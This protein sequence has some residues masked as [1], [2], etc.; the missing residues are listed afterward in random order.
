MVELAVVLVL[1][2]L[3]VRGLPC[4]PS[5]IFPVRDTLVWVGA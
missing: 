4:L 5:A 3:P 1:S 2:V